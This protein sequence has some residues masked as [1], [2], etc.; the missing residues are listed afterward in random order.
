MFTNKHVFVLIIWSC[1]YRKRK[2]KIPSS[3]NKKKSTLKKFLTFFQKK[4]FL[5]FPECNFWT[6]RL[7]RFL[8]FLRTN[9]F[10]YFEKWNF[11]ALNQEWTFQAQ[12]TKKTLSKKIV[13]FQE[14][15]RFLIVQEGT[16]KAWK[17]EISYISGNGTPKEKFSYTCQKKQNFLNENSFL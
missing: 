3:K 1:T 7:K 6:P 12:K 11:I 2:K 10:L 4:K 15:E 17:T 8:Y 9:F 14:M 13:I 5:V 16:C